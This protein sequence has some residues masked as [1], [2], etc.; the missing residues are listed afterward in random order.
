M[1]EV[2]SQHFPGFPRIARGG[3]STGVAFL[4]LI[5][6]NELFSERGVLLRSYAAWM[7]CG[8]VLLALPGTSRAQEKPILLLLPVVVHSSESPTYLREGLLD[9]LSTRFLQGGVFELQIAQN[10]ENATTQ[11]GEALIRGRQRGADFVLFGSFT[12]FGEGAS[13][14]MQAAS[15]VPG[16]EEITLREIFVHSGSIGEVIPDLD[17]LVGKV[18]RFAVKD[19]SPVQE[20]SPENGSRPQGTMELLLRVKALEDALEGLRGTPEP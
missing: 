3:S 5:G 10:P 9:M 12:R 7:G 15:T 14:D 8:L 4:S 6:V 11:L 16:E 2:G 20:S 19:F 1:P 13:L 18:T 17:N